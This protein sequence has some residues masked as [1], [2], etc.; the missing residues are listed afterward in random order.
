MNCRRFCFFVCVWNT[1]GTTEWICTKFTLRH[2][3]SLTRTS[4]KVKVKGQGH[5][6]LLVAC[7]WFMFAKTSLAS[8]VVCVWNIL[9]TAEWICT[10]FTWKTCLVHRSKQFEGQVKGQGHQGQKM[11]FSALSATCVQFMFGKTSLAFSLLFDLL[12]TVSLVFLTV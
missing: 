1:P 6:G 11:A 9:G 2:I 8:S 12:Q 5:Q 4:L 3:W 7:V 10:K